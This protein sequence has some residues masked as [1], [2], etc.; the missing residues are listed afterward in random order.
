MA[1]RINGK[2]VTKEAYEAMIA[3]TQREALRKGAPASTRLTVSR[4]ARRA[5]MAAQSG[6]GNL[7]KSVQSI[8]P[9]D[10]HPAV[11]RK[12]LKRV[13]ASIDFS[14]RMPYAEDIIRWSKE[15]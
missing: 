5:P 11:L 12:T 14:G 8:L 7:A 3:R 6:I 15:V 9:P 10:T 1:F 4:A 13:N 2:F